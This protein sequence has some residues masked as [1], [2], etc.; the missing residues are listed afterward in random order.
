[1]YSFIWVFLSE[2][3]LEKVE[4]IGRNLDELKAFLEDFF[5][6]VEKSICC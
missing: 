6:T 2:T 3:V 5:L 4:E 1:M